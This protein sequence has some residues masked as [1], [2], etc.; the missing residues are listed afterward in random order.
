MPSDLATR[1]S[2]A[3][4]P[5][6]D[7]FFADLI[8]ANHILAHQRIVD[9]FG[10]ISAR[11]PQNPQTFYL[12]ANR[13]PALVSR[14]EDIVEYRVEDA[15]AVN[16]DAPREYLE[17]FI[18]SEIYKRFPDVGSVV[19]AHSEEV[20]VFGVTGVPLRV[21]FH[22]GGVMGSTVPVFDAAQHYSSSN[23]HDLLISSPQLGAHLAA[24]FAPSSLLAKTGS[25]L[26]SFIPGSEEQQGTAYPPHQVVLM[27]G[28]GFTALARDVKEAVYRAV[29]TTVNAR[30]QR[31]A[32]LL[33]GAFNSAVAAERV[34]KVGK[35]GYQASSSSSSSGTKLGEVT[36]L[37][38]REAADAWEA[39]AGQV[40]R[41]WEL[42]TEEVKA[43][44]LY[45]NE[46]WEDDE[47]GES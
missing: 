6:P 41:P 19:H 24:A 22:M 25:V 8:T 39:N 38:D 18:H 16:P 46:Y 36:F 30:I 32:V 3:T 26:K 2:T 13:A 43:S 35:E 34:T 7:S 10:H 40:H 4:A 47:Q 21:V 37:S 33:Q 28:H 11:S 44:S 15:S 17:R 14:R 27:R 9:G 42:W 1:L 29:Y 31:E 12:S 23:R 5:I 20:I 45:R